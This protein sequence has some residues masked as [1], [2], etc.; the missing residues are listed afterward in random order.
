MYLL[1]KN[2]E[3][4]SCKIPTNRNIQAPFLPRILPITKLLGGKLMKKFTK[5]GVAAVVAVFA[6]VVMGCASTKYA[7]DGAKYESVTS[8]YTNIDF[9]YSDGSALAYYSYPVSVDGHE[10]PV[11]KKAGKG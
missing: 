1:P 5:L 4:N 2:R 10:L 3:G 9:S 7:L 6:L 8:P 11:I